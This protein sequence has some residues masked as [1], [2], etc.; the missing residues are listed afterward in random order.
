MNRGRLT[1]E[2]HKRRLKLLLE[3]IFL[4][5]YATRK[6]LD[7]FVRIA[8]NI[9]YPQWLIAHSVRQG[10]LHVYSEP[11]VRIKIY[12]LTQ[13]GKD[14]LYPTEPFIEHY[15][16]ERRHAGINT[17]LHHNAMVE[18]YFQF[19]RHF[20]IKEWVCEWV[21]RIGKRKR[22]KIPD[23]VISLSDGKKL[24]LEVETSYKTLDVLKNFVIRYRY[25][26]DK[27]SEYHGVLLVAHSKN[28]YEGIKVKL[29]KIA[30]EFCNRAFL[31]ADLEMLRSGMCLY[32]ENLCRIEE[33]IRLLGRPSHE[34]V[35]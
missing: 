5:R 26:I 22:E 13:K 2:E 7:L 34:A 32:K 28:H 3:F 10:Y 17:F 8:M 23:A 19:F 29:S 11:L 25:Y 15:H 24:A 12:H 16:F 9:N 35:S 30:P 21:L 4:F 20:E 33:A 14:F 27:A 6:Q 1:L 31:L 18:V